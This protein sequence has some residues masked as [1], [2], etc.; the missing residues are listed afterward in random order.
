M[1]KKLFFALVVV[2]LVV[3]AIVYAKLGQFTAMG[4]AAANMALPPE[5]VTALTVSGEQW[6][7]VIATTATVSAVQGSRSVPRSVAG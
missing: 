7:Q 6:E 3:G 2:A 4:E 5:T 1:L